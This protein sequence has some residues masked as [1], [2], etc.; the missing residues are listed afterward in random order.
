VCL[1]R[2]RTSYS[3]LAGLDLSEINLKEANLSGSDLTDA[4]NADFTGAKNAPEKYLKN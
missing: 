1:Y 3:Y 2:D 4:I